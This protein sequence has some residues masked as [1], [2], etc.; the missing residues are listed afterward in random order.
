M[1]Y[2]VKVDDQ[3]FDVEVVDL[4]ARPVI[5]IVDGEQIEVWPEAN[6]SY[7]LPEAAPLKEAVIMPKITRTS[8]VTA[9]ERSARENSPGLPQVSNIVRAPI[10]GTVLSISVKPG[11]KVSPGDELCVLEAMKMKN[12]IRAVRTGIISNVHVHTGQTV[13]H[14]DVLIEYEN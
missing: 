7:T 10:P 8:P 6:V 12:I 2:R 1:K 13:K 14:Q 9:K 4:Y 5:A 11:A 3:F